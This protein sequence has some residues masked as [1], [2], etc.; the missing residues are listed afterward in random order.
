MSEVKEVG[1][2]ILPEVQA[3]E[4]TTEQMQKDLDYVIAQ[5]LTRTMLQNGLI[6]V[7]EFDKITALNRESFAPYLVELMG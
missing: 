3:R 6:S 4:M 7:E 1:K 2:S 5:K